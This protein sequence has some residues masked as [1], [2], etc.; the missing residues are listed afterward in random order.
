M[1]TPSSDDYC[2]Q[3]S[4]E[5]AQLIVVIDTEEEFNWSKEFSRSNNSV[6]AMRYIGRVQAI[7]DRYGITPVYVVDYPVATNPDGYKP[8]QEIYSSGRCLIGAHLHPWVNPPYEEDVNRHNSFPGNLPPHLEFAKLK[9]LRDCIGEQFGIIP[10]IYKAGRYGVGP[11]TAD[12][13]IAQG[14]EIDLSVCPTMNYSSEGGPDFT[15]SSNWPYWISRERLLEIPLTI[16]FS[17]PLR[18]WGQSIHRVVSSSAW[19]SCRAV[20]VLS[21]LGLVSKGSLSPE[22]FLSSEHIR[23]AKALFSDGLRV[24]SFAFHS[25]SVEAGHTPYVTSEKD[26]SAFLS[27]LDRFFDFFM[28]DLGGCPT[29]PLLLKQKFSSLSI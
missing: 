7:F 3:S 25:P 22:G 4:F 15:W 26:L 13:L 1:L 6:K 14:F 19:E 24:F 12:N 21:R 8:L 9:I 27:R 2:Q 29:T 28:G 11:H 5:K 18:Q 23:L 20:G 10:V 16:G 17:G